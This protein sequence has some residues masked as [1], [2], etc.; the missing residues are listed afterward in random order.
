M[1]YVPWH[2]LMWRW[3]Y[4]TVE[5][6]EYWCALQ[7]VGE[8]DRVLKKVQHEGVTRP[9]PDHLDCLKRETTEKIF[10]GGANAEAMA[11]EVV[12][13]KIRCDSIDTF[14]KFSFGEWVRS[15]SRV[16]PR[17]QWAAGVGSVDLHVLGKES[18]RVNV[19][20]LVRPPG[21]RPW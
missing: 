6:R 10:E 8:D 3:H 16:V 19:V 5:F 2:V 11:L 7:I 1:K 20:L 15:S 17:E 12:H 18:V 4:E 14:H 13:V 9:S 21:E